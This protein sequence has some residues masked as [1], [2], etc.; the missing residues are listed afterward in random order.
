MASKT[1]FM[2]DSTGHVFETNYPEYHKEC[3]Q[4]STKEGKAA[5]VAQYKQ[6]LAKYVREGVTLYTIV[7]KVSSSGM[8]RNIDVYAIED[9]KPVYLSGYAAKVL[10]WKMA[11]DRGIVVSGC[12]MDMGFHLVECLAR[13]CGADYKKIRQEWL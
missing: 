4:I 9:N 8:S 11:K 10:G 3:Q 5:I 7:R 13:T 1:F 2:Q 6:T 12:G